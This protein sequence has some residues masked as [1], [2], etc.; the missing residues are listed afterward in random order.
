M[1]ELAKPLKIYANHHC[2][3]NKLKQLQFDLIPI[4]FRKIPLTIY[5]NFNNMKQQEFFNRYSYSIRT[6]KIGGGAFGTVYK[7]HDNVLH[8]DVAL[9][10][11]EVKIIG[12]K[13]FS[14]KDE[15]DAIKDLPPHPNIA[16][17]ESM[18]TFDTPHGIFDYA[19]MQYYKDGNLSNAIKGGLSEQQK[20]EIAIDLLKGIQHLHQ[21]KVVH[22]DLKPGNILVINH[23]EKVIPLITDF[24][25]SKH[26]KQEAMSRF[27]NSFGGGTLKYSSPEQLKGETL[28]LNTDLWAYG[29]IV[30]EVFTGK[31]L[32]S[33]DGHSSASAEAEEEIFKQIKEKD[34]SSDLNALPE[35]WRKA[36]SLCLIKEAGKRIKT[37][38]ELIQIING[39]ETSKTKTE[40]KTKKEEPKTII[41][42]NKEEPKQEEK[43]EYIDSKDFKT[44][45]EE[46]PK[47]IKPTPTPIIKKEGPKKSYTPIISLS[48]VFVIIAII[49]GVYFSQSTYSDAGFKLPQFDMVYV[50]GGT[51][52]MGCTGE[53]G[54]DCYDSEKPAHSVTLSSYYMGKYEVTQAQW[55]AVMG[56]NPS[57]TDRG[58]GVNYP[59]NLVS[60]NDIQTF[61]SKLNQ[62]T[63]KSYRLPTEAEWEF[64]ARG[65]NSS[66]GFKYS[67][68]HTLS[69]VGW[70]TYNSGSKTHPVGQKQANELGLYDMSGNVWEWCSDWYGDYSSSSETNP[71]GPATGSYRVLRGGSWNYYARDCRVS[72]RHGTD[73]YDRNYDHGFR[74][75][76]VP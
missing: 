44:I 51:F 12:E 70:Y 8:R 46:K 52:T 7:A 10:I 24:G 33:A 5:L 56:S 40:P 72:Y 18:E 74:L 48:V 15:F 64:A 59:V 63:D 62:L 13:E 28:R 21:N 30:Y 25:L 1:T 45:I 55:K 31:N 17:Y 20:E 75:V 49:A 35:K 3:S 19:I 50:K 38:E 36:V 37:A 71:K 39:Q 57:A 11:S 69:N 67:G 65:G 9:K 16:H 76:L 53:Q 22:R 60:W 2:I 23:G 47:P 32:F 26:T 27:S 4:D 73:A 66:K 54:S 6:D 41:E 42:T 61:I 58:V 34:I 68:S 43:D 14:L 29:V